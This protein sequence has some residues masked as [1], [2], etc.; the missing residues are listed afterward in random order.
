MP[1]TVDVVVKRIDILTAFSGEE[2]EKLYLAMN[3]CEG[4]PGKTEQ[5]IEAWEYFT[6]QFYP[7]IE[8]LKKEYK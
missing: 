3:M 1:E 2:I 5:E 4:G 7:Y 8:E 6:T